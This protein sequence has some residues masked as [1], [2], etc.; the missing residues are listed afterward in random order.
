MNGQCAKIGEM[1]GKIYKILEKKGE[2]PLEALSKESGV[3]DAALLNQAIGW[4]CREDK[5][6]L[7]KKTS[8]THASLV[9]AS[10]AHGCC[11]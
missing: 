3:H 10:A 9:T 4:L 5:L 8:G 1:A 11:Q 6:H 2:L 7:E